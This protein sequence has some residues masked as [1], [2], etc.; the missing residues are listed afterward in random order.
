MMT[1]RALLPLAA[2]VTRT[3]GFFAPNIGRAWLPRS[4]ITALRTLSDDARKIESVG[5]SNNNITQ[6]N[7]VML[8]PAAG[9]PLVDNVDDILGIDPSSIEIVEIAKEDR[10]EMDLQGRFFVHMFRGSASYIANHRNTQAV[11]H[12]PGYLVDDAN[13][14]RD[15]MSDIALTWLL[16]MKIVLVVG[17]RYQI[18]K[19]IPNRSSPNG[20]HV[21]DEA[22]LRVVKEEAGFVRFEVERQLA[23]ALR[24]HGGTEFGNVVS[25]NFYSAQPFG[26]L[27]GIDYKYTGFTRRVEIDKIRQVQGSNDICLLTT[28]GVSPSGEVFNVCSEALTSHV[29]GSLGASKVIFFTERNIVVRS[30]VHGKQVQHLRL[31][32]ARNVLDFNKIE[33]EKRGTV[34]VHDE[35]VKNQDKAVLDTLT[36]IGWAT[37]AL[38]AGV[39]RAHIIAPTHGSVLQEL[40]TRDGS[41]TLISR[42]LYEGIRRATVHDISGIVDL[43]SPLIRMGTLVDRPRDKLEKDI[44]GYYVYT[45]DNLVLAC[46]QLKRFENGFAEIGCLV[47][48][49]EY[50][51]QGRGDAMLGYLERVCMQNNAP[52]VF[53]LSTQTMEWFVERG[54]DEV[55]VDRLPPSRQATYNYE[56]N[57]KIYMKKISDDRDLDASELWWNR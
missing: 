44:D 48:S 6:D 28:L 50:R 52:T 12:I 3:M 1:S 31:T 21:T 36:K 20:L 53:V 54:F 23:R 11:Y 51:S 29:A 10:Q 45:R 56:R 55:G 14:C 17:C 46:A 39:R 37:I 15:L 24:V 49:K 40:Y 22:M 16:G 33:V 34:Q 38:E 35:Q 42:D 19:R 27:G 25:G 9:Q 7:N 41:G 47:V 13:L 8:A 4:P 26:I 2:L 18:D 32:D 43:I 57:S 30:K 5:A